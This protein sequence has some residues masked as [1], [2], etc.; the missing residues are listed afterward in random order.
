MANN[1]KLS[2]ADIIKLLN[3]KAGRSIAYSLAKD[4]PTEVKEWIS[5]GSRYLDSIICRGQLAGIPVGKITEIAGLSSSGKSY[6]A[7]QIA[8]NAQHMGIK[9]VYFDSENAQDP[10]FLEN[11]GCDITSENGVI[12]L[13]AQWTEQVLEMI[14][15]LLATGEKYLFIWDSLANTPAKAD[16]E[17][18]FNPQ[19]S[20]AVRPRILS[21]GLAKLVQPIG[22]SKSTFLILNQLKTKITS[23]AWEALADPWFTPGGMAAIYNY[24]LRIWLTASKSKRTFIEDDKGYRIGT[25]VKSKLKKS[26]FGTEGRTC[27]FKIIWGDPK[28]IGILD[29]ESWLEAI[30]PSNHLTSAGAWYKLDGY[31]K[32]FTGSQFAN[33]VRTDAKFKDLVLKIMDD[34][35]IRKFDAREGNASKFYD[36]EE[37]NAKQPEE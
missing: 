8:R 31:D 3:K 14:E 9:V 7:A 32:K 26:R 11:S 12:Y 18:D 27:N 34:E 23:N 10:A 21:K 2:S 16:I 33:L 19:S 20:M 13:Q 5:T 28:Q 30:K 24:S 6:M 29:E 35:V 17:G 22:D 37:A 25:E 36:H 4:N 15:T 1:G